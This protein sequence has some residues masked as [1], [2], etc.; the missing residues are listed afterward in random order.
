MNK[1]VYRWKILI[2]DFFNKIPAVI[3]IP[4]ILLASFLIAVFLIWSGTKVAVI[5]MVDPFGS[6]GNTNG[7]KALSSNKNSNTEDDF[8]SDTYRNGSGNS[9]SGETGSAGNSGQNGGSLAGQTN[10]G[11]G[12]SSGDTGASSGL[13]DG[14]S[15]TAGGSSSESSSEQADVGGS[16]SSSSDSGSGGASQGAKKMP[17]SSSG[18]GIGN[19]NYNSNVSAN[20]TYPEG[21]VSLWWRRAPKI[22][23]DCYIKENGFPDFLASEPYF[24]DYEKNEDCYVK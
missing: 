7:K 23:R 4:G 16:H 1:T 14:T 10:N 12:E 18:G 22:E 8:T 20:C 15:Q 5:D 2:S 11:S 6:S 21:D 3:L 17:S 9:A 24:C 19:E 13:S